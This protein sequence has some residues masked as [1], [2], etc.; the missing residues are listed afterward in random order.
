MAKPENIFISSLNRHLP[1]LSQ[2]HRE[3]MANPYRGGTA[4]M[5]YSGPARDLWI[6]WKF[7]P[8]VPVLKTMSVDL[9]KNYLS[10]LQAQWLRTQHEF[11]RNV[12]VGVGCPEGGFVLKNLEWEKP[13][14]ADSFRRLLLSRAELA[15]Q[16][17]QFVTGH[18]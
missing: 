7:V 17:A 16:I 1:P 5:W 14:S 15:Q 10:P 18:T 13:I 8:K 6:E 11:G 12:W 2:V 9:M 3:K 4:D